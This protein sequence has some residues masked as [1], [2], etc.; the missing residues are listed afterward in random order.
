MAETEDF[1]RY[2]D[3]A[4]RCRQAAETSHWPEVRS[5]LTDL[6]RRYE[7]IADHAERED[8]RRS[9]ARVNPQTEPLAGGSTGISPLVLP[10]SIA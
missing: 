1:K 4:R 10:F 9:T 3:Q 6:A 7:L 2:R 5:Q 8:K